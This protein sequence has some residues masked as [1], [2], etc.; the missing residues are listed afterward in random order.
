MIRN[1]DKFQKILRDGPLVVWG[2]FHFLIAWRIGYNNGIVG[3]LFFIGLFSL[4]TSLIIYIIGYK[5]FPLLINVQAHKKYQLIIYI[6]S[7]ILLFIFFIM[8]FLYSPPKFHSQ[9]NGDIPKWFSIVFWLLMIA[10]GGMLI[11][12][13]KLTQFYYDGKITEVSIKA[14]RAKVEL[15]FLKNQISPHFLFNA[16]NNIYGLAFMGDKQAADMISILSQIL[17]YLLYECDQTKVSI[18][19]EK[20]LIHNYLKLQSYKYEDTINLDFY[21]EGLRP[22]AMITP[23]ILI[24]FV[25]NCFKHSDIEQNPEAWIKIS[26]ELDNDLLLFK[27]ENSKRTSYNSERN[28]GIGLTNSRKLLEVYYPNAHQLEIFDQE[29]VFEIELKIKL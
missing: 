25:E 14:E 1:L 5:I 19:K 29:E 17:R 8:A 27:T 28:A 20:E 3:S 10:L 2:L 6:G 21:I 22:D 13:S 9:S 26:M 15:T 24:N 11:I 7:V 18:N 12:S 23:M 16:L 4:N